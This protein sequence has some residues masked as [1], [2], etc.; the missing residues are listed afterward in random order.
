MAE[1]QVPRHVAFLPQ[2]YRLNRKEGDFLEG[3]ARVG[4][5]VARFFFQAGSV[6]VSLLFPEMLPETPFRKV[7][8]GLSAEGIGIRVLQGGSLP[9]G[10]GR[11]VNLGLGYS[12]KELILEVLKAFPGEL[13]REETMA[14]EFR[15][16]GWFEPD[17][18]VLTGGSRSVGAAL[19]WSIAYSELFFS[20][21][22]WSVFTVDEAARAFLEYQGRK[23]RF[24]RV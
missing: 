12:E 8:Q 10:D 14:E 24:G 3:S 21:Q 5:D 11:L 16:R 4:A 7:L 15:L 17:L 19:T 9:P 13:F 6:Q 18:V 2:D 23:R 1:Q 20:V 22:G